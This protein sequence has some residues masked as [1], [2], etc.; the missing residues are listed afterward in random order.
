MRSAS[1][2]YMSVYRRMRQNET[3]SVKKTCQVSVALN[4]LRGL[5][6]VRIFEVECCICRI[7]DI[8]N[9]QFGELGTVHQI[10]SNRNTSVPPKC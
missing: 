8:Y 4:G 6:D 7:V 5:L 9:I 2:R 1:L 10:K 3:A